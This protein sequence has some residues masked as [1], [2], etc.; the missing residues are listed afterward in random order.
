MIVRSIYVR[1]N[2]PTRGNKARVLPLGGFVI[3]VISRLV[4]V[5]EDSLRKEREKERNI[6]EDRKGERERKRAKARARERS[7]EKNGGS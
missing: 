7:G 5:A 2:D 6:E 4:A 3:F 1:R